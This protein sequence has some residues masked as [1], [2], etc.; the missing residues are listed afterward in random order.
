MNVAYQQVINGQLQETVVGKTIKKVIANQNPHSFVWFA[1][2]PERAFQNAEAAGDVAA[3]LMG[4]TIDSCAVHM[5]GYGCY[6]FLYAGNRALMTDMA[7]RYFT[8]AEKL[9]KRH[10]LLI[11]FEDDTSLCF[12]ASLGGAL[13]LFEVDENGLPLRYAN[14]MPSILS[15]EFTY[16][17]FEKMTACYQESGGAK[18]TVKQLLAARNRF[19]GLDNGLLQDILWEARINPKSHVA[20]LTEEEKHRLFQAIK[21]VPAAM[22]AQG[23]KDTDKDIYGRLGGYVTRASRNTCGKPCA[24]CGTPIVKEAYMGGAVF[25]CPCCQERK[26]AAKPVKKG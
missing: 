2:E 19:P 26:E 22:I 21:T 8:P 1:M 9:P 11:V 13:F 16:A 6:N 7:P 12:A 17:F 25:Y 24:R 4:K 23:G 20:S 3:Y 5:G 15:E 10:Q 18:F 14:S